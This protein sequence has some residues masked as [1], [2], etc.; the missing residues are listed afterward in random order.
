M[1][2]FEYEVVAVD[3]THGAMEVM[4]TFDDGT[5]IRVG[6]EIPHENIDLDAFLAMM[7]PEHLKVTAP[8]PRKISVGLKGSGITSNSEGAEADMERFHAEATIM[9]VTRDLPPV[10]PRT[11]REACEVDTPYCML[12]PYYRDG[13]TPVA[14]HAITPDNDG[15]N[16]VTVLKDLGR[17]IAHANALGVPVIGL[18]VT[19]TQSPSRYAETYHGAEIHRIADTASISIAKP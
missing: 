15:P 5:E 18:D 8:K 11:M 3:E 12:V 19:E 7:A 17:A 1:N 14:A 2:I 9:D 6:M 13:T 10:S 16:P 4:Y